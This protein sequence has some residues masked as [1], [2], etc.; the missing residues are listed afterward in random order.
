MPDAPP[1]RDEGHTAQVQ[2][3]GEDA[4]VEDECQTQSGVLD[5]SLDGDG[6]AV[7]LVHTQETWQRVTGEEGNAVVDKHQQEGEVD[8]A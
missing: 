1:C 5:T 4:W 2:L 3:G 7:Q 8:V 6:S